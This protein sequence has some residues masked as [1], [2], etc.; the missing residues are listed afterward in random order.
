MAIAHLLGD[1][2]VKLVLKEVK[3]GVWVKGGDGG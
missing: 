3:M 1:T 2:F